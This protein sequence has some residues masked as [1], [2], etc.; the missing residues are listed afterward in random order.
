MLVMNALLTNTIPQF[1]RAQA[2]EDTA[3]RLM[4]TGSTFTFLALHHD[5][6]TPVAATNTR[7]MTTHVG[8]RR[9][10]PGC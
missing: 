4:E 3:P 5:V 6:R 10:P 1:G 2:W 9:I 8:Q 7:Y